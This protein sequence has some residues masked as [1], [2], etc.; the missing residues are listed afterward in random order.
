MKVKEPTPTTWGGCVRWLC[1]ELG[2]PRRRLAQTMGIDE[3][4]VSRWARDVTVPSAASQTIL[5]S[6]LKD[7]VERKRQREAND[8]HDALGQ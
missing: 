1:H 3:S 2:W 8:L 6:L 5:K 7:A 4:L